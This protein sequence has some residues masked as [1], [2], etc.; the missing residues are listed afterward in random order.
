MLSIWFQCPHPD[1][2]SCPKSLTSPCPDPSDDHLRLG[3]NNRAVARNANIHPPIVPS[4]HPRIGRQHS[5]LMSPSWPL[6]A[7][8]SLCPR[9]TRYL[10]S[11]CFFVPSCHTS[12]M[13]SGQPTCGRSLRYS[14]DGCGLSF[15]EPPC[16]RQHR[17][18][19]GSLVEH[20]AVGTVLSH[21]PMD[22]LY[23]VK[24]CTRPFKLPWVPRGTRNRNR[25]EHPC[26]NLVNH[27]SRERAAH[28]LL[29]SHFPRCMYIYLAWRVF[30]LRS[31]SLLARHFPNHQ[32]AIRSK[33]GYRLPLSIHL[34]PSP[35]LSYLALTSFFFLSHNFHISR[36]FLTQAVVPF[37][38]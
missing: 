29:H 9:G 35:L 22:L 15:V 16:R 5:A 7:V 34:L 28:S 21:F 38:L 20:T 10:F 33:D 27:P 6:N 37:S 32:S 2:P 19:P 36:K 8:G 1:C 31:S 17:L 30:L 4:S 24:P 25:H 12:T 13:T 26:H 11:Y 3:G 23:R 18:P 14:W